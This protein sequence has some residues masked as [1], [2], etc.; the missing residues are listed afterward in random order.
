M[1]NIIHN[2]AVLVYKLEPVEVIHGFNPITHR[3]LEDLE[4]CWKNKYKLFNELLNHN[5][6]YNCR[7]YTFFFNLHVLKE[8]NI[9][10]L[11]E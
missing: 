8:T 5:F 7:I 4:A 11:T 9:T 6:G 3:H 2:S 10:Q 1:E